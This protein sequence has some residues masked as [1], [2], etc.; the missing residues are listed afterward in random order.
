MAS[1]NGLTN[2]LRFVDR[3]GNVDIDKAFD[4]YCG[5]IKQAKEN[6]KVILKDKSLQKEEILQHQSQLLADEFYTIIKGFMNYTKS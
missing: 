3:E 1:N 4:Y 2:S 6:I 5:N